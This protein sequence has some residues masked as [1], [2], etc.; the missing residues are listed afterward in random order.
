MAIRMLKLLHNCSPRS[1]SLAQLAKKPLSH[2]KGC[3]YHLSPVLNS[4]IP[5][6]T[7]DHK[8]IKQT[9]T[10]KKKTPVEE[11]EA[12]FKTPKYHVLQE[13]GYLPIYK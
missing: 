1:F 6:R 12:K 13:E 10:V 4:S 8:P 9:I 2:H 11:F 7:P 5:A 3:L